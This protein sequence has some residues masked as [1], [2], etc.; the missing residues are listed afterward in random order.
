MQ[1]PHEARTPF[2][3]RVVE[4]DVHGNEVETARR[5]VSLRK[6]RIVRPRQ[7]GASESESASINHV[8][9]AVR[10]Q[11]RRSRVHRASYVQYVAE[12]IEVATVRADFEITVV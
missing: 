7:R 10:R 1:R 2:L 11:P 6:R 12:C 5:Y 8:L 9:G 3:G 4:S